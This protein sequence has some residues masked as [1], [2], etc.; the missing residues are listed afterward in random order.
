MRLQ[1]YKEMS[2]LTRAR[3]RHVKMKICRFVGYRYMFLIF[4]HF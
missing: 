4:L 3:M 2:I 1:T